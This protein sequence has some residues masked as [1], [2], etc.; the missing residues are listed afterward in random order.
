IQTEGWSRGD[1]FD[2]TNLSW[3]NPSPNM[4]SLNAATLYPG[5]CLIE[6]P[7]NLSVGRGTD[8]PFEPI[9]ADFIH[10]R[11]LAAALNKRDIPGVRVYPT[12]FT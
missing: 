1:W 6:F 12:S 10:G 9:G 3:T 5:I 8:S 7:K 2:A 11:E 4:R